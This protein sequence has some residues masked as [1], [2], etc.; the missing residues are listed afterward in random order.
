[1]FKYFLFYMCMLQCDCFGFTH[2]HIYMRRSQHDFDTYNCQQM[3]FS[4]TISSSKI[5]DEAGTVHCDSVNVCWQFAIVRFKEKVNILWMN[6]IK[7]L[8]AQE[9]LKH[10]WNYL[11]YR[12]AFDENRWKRYSKCNFSLDIRFVFVFRVHHIKI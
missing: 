4:C 1:M 2:I 10:Y 3:E 5:I 7:M 8:Q 12:F 9:M 6:Q 11:F